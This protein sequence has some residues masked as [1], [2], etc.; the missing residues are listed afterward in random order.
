[1]AIDTHR[2]TLEA[3]KTM[4]QEVNASQESVETDFLSNEVYVYDSY[5]RELKLAGEERT[6][7]MENPQK[8][9]KPMR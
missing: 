7:E 5:T 6:K 4:I 2:H 3:L 1:M 8:Q 9:E